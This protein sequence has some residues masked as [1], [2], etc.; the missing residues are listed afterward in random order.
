[1][2]L[3]YLEKRP[4][5]V[6]YSL[7]NKTANKVARALTEREGTSARDILS[8]TAVHVACAQG[9]PCLAAHKAQPRTSASRG[10][11]CTDEPLQQI[12]NPLATR[13]SKGTRRSTEP[14]AVS[15]AVSGVLVSATQPRDT[16]L[17]LVF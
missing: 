8:V 2:T 1:M 10:I 16:K 9:W 12:V 7:S 4:G 11:D 14:S 13:R 5:T 6:S 17:P 3:S 15:P